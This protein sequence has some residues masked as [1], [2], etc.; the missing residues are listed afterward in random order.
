MAKA[1]TRSIL[2]FCRYRCWDFRCSQNDFYRTLTKRPD[3]LSG[4]ALW[5]NQ[6]ER[7]F[8]GNAVSPGLLSCALP[9]N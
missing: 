8:F 4:D 5:L 3:E 6:H 7:D 9:T 1:F 2:V